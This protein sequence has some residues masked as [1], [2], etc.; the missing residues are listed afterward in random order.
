MRQT[1]CGLATILVCALAA[2]QTERQVQVPLRLD[3]AFVQQALVQQVYGGKPGKAEVWNDGK[4]CAYVRLWDPVVSSAGDR[5]RV[6]TRGEGRLGTAVGGL[7]LSP[8]TWDG[9]LELIEVPSVGP[10]G[11]AIRFAIADSHVYDLQW[12]K[13]LMTGRLWDLVKDRVH[14]RFAAVSIDIGGPLRDLRELLPFWVAGRDTLQV[15]RM[16]E[17]VRVSAVAV[18]DAGLGATLAFEVAAPPATSPAPAEPTLTPEELRRWDDALQRWDAFLTFV[19][20]VFGRDR[21]AP[22]LHAALRT[23]LIEGRYEIVEVLAPTTPE[24]YDPT[25]A[26]F[27]KT[28]ERLAP[29]LRNAA[30]TQ[31]GSVGLR[32]ISFITAADALVALHEL[33]P[34]MGIE[35][36]GDGL[37]RMA[38]IL[39]PTADEDP[40]AYSTEVDPELRDLFGFGAPLPPPDVP[41]DAVESQSWW[42]QWWLTRPALAGEAPPPAS[43]SGWLPTTDRI[44]DYL[45][46]VRQVLDDATAATL[47]RQPLGESYLD[48][49]RRLVLATAWQESCWRQ[50]VRSGGQATYIRSPVGAVGL[51]QIN[52]RVWRGLYD[53]RGLRWDIRYNARAGTEILQHYLRDYAIARGEHERP[54]GHDNL[55]RATYAVYNGGPG[56]LARYRKPQTSRQLRHID[57]V[58]WEKFSAVSEGRESEVRR[59]FVGA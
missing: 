57:R 54:G 12:K 36:S 2:A 56:H 21:A 7:C 14:P 6:V 42:R 45:R 4:D 15:R 8:I 29:V 3:H 41:P 47:D 59:C 53:I 25:P 49:Y 1:C 16:L 46:A 31:P 27:L 38:R 19:I 24:A 22:D 32:Y 18:T 51:M 23:T 43:V 30:A 52:E 11:D 17:S 44:D 39:A 48:L 55:A 28:W 40:L 33:G 13:P 35:I 58:F 26:L 10:D 9:F 20:K 34:G 37:R 50:F 5:L